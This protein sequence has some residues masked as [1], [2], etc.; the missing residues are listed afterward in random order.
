MLLN[1]LMGYRS[2]GKTIKA[3]LQELIANGKIEVNS[4]LM[5]VTIAPKDKPYVYR[6]WT[7][8]RGY[9]LFLEYLEE[10]PDNPHLVKVLSPVRELT[11]NY[12]GTKK[13]DVKV[14]K[15][16]KLTPLSPEERRFMEEYLQTMRRVWS[17]SGK[18]PTY[19]TKKFEQ[20]VNA[21]MG[22]DVG[23]AAFEDLH[24]GNVMKRGKTMV[25]IDPFADA[26][27]GHTF[28]TH[29]GVRDIE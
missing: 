1:E 24:E 5:A 12:L 19:I 2:S 27:H 23:N 9:E 14:V 21:I 10:N 17:F 11:I 13:V 18:K 3:I 28:V 22:E 25:I 26:N 4:G 7:Q 16:E 6:I 20:T 8:D 29:S 15:L